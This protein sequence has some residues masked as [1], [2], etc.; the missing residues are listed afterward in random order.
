MED[1]AR[2]DKE[3]VVKLQGFYEQI[4]DQIQ[5]EAIFLNSSEPEPELNTWK[6]CKEQYLCGAY[7]L[8]L[9]GAKNILSRFQ[10]CYY[11]SDWMTS[12]L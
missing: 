8:H 9:S 7:I 5:W 6:V 12:R 3:W 10:N 4:H 1:D 2:F 11:S